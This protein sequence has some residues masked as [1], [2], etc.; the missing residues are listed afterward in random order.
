MKDLHL[1]QVVVTEA[2]RHGMEVYLWA[3]LFD[4]GG[5]ADN[6][7]CKE[8]PNFGQLNL[9]VE[10][11]EWMPSDRY[12]VR[13]QNGPIELAYPEA[14]KALIDIYLYYI[15]RDKLDGITFFTYCENYGLRFEDEF[16]YS[17]PIV[18]EYKRCAMAS[19]IRTRRDFDRHLWHYLRGEYVTQFLRE[20]KAELVKRHKKLGV[21]LNPREPNMTDRW[22]VPAYF[23]TSGRIYMDWEKWVREGIVDQ[24]DVSGTTPH[25]LQNRT[26]DNV[27]QATEG[28]GIAFAVQANNPDLPRYKPPSIARGPAHDAFRGRHR[29]LPQARPTPTCRPASALQGDDIYGGHAL[30][31]RGGRRQS[32][33]S[34]PAGS[35]PG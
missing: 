14:R 30:H 5:P 4:Y 10:H 13:Q 9:T 20:L 6:G 8:Y 34:T 25:E 3:P 16:G 22:N 31:G 28:K 19:D 1:N 17:Q 33:P 27:L 21:R 26:L 2:H 35:S 12:G 11:P 18:D 29:L 7:G 15:D 32:G 24:L 23:L